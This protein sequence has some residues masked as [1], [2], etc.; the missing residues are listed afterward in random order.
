MIMQTKWTRDRIDE[1]AF[2][3]EHDQVF[4]FITGGHHQMN[5]DAISAAIFR[6]WI[7]IR[8]WKGRKEREKNNLLAVDLHQSGG[9]G[10]ES[11]S[12]VSQPM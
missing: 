3:L 7:F 8:R 5:S 4:A 10:H 9:L 11:W 2:I 6:N 12:L 1:F